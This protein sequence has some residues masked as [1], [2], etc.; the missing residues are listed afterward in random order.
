MFG[1]G[2]QDVLDDT[3]LY[4]A[5]R[6]FLDSPSDH[7]L[8]EGKNFTDTNVQQS[9]AR[10]GESRASLRSSFV[11]QTMRPLTARGPP[12][13]RGSSNGGGTRTRNLSMREPPDIDRINAEDF[14]DNLDG[15]ACAAFSNVTEEVRYFFINFV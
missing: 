15:M 13:P 9:L 6:S 7:M 11:S 14:V 1:G 3:Q 4:H 10:L 2:A 12:I 5:L 8:Y